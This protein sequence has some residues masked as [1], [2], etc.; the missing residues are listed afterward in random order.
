MSERFGEVPL[1]A[2]VD[3]VPGV[4]GQPIVME[5]ELIEPNLYLNQAPGAAERVAAAIVHRTQ[6]PDRPDR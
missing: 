4:D 6:P 3:L 1:Y 5:L 2:R